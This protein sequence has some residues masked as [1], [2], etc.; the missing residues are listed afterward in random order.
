MTNTIK[1]V[2]YYSDG[3][4]LNLGEQIS[5]NNLDRKKLSAFALVRDGK[6]ILKLHL[7]S[8]QRLIWRKRTF[9]S[10]GK[11]KID[12]H[13]LGWQKTVNGE[14]IQSIAYVLSDGRVEMAGAFREDH[15]IFGKIQFLKEEI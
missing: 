15:P 14:N 6:E 12:I 5:Y 10:P 11:E 3:S 4:K 7:D 8:G 2:A 13:I 1:P 9:L